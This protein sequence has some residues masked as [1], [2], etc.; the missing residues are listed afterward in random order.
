VVKHAGQPRALVQLGDLLQ[1][2]WAGIP[3]HMPA[4]LAQRAGERLQ[5]LVPVAHG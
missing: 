4:Q 5:R 3:L 1:L 2:L